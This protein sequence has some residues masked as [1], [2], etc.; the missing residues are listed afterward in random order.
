MVY[1]FTRERQDYSDFASGRVLYS[2]PGRTAFPVRLASEIFQRCL[3][4]RTRQGGTGAGVLYDPCCG[5]AALLCTLAYLH[6]DTLDQV[7]GSD[8]DAEA[9]LL[10]R[11][12]LSLLTLKGM[13]ERIAGIEEMLSRYQKASHRHALASA[14]LLR[15]RL[16]ELTSTHNVTT[17][18]FSADALQGADILKQLGDLKVDTVLTDIPYGSSSSWQFSGASRASFSNPAWHLLQSLLPVLSSCSV[19]AIVA[20]K[21]QK[22]A[23]EEYTRV[24]HFQVG[25][26]KVVFLVPARMSLERG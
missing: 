24:G 5:S 26:R 22:I 12:N 6:W 25:Q 21:Q 10:A 17:R 2:F 16:E 3:E 7:I 13:D 20:Q 23:H 1:R 14:T 11:R 19:V 18:L 15:D 4:F 9:L 8:I